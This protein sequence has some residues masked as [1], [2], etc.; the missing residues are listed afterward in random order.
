MA[1]NLQKIK[2]PTGLYRELNRFGKHKKGNRGTKIT[3]RLVDLWETSLCAELK[4]AGRAK[5]IQHLARISCIKRRGGKKREEEDMYLQWEGEDQYGYAN[6]Y[7]AEFRRGPTGTDQ[8]SSL[9]TSR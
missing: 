3:C 1:C 4:S 2:K 6:K 8:A 5:N 9:L 7:M